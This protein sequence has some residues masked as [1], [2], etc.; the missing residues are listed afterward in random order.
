MNPMSAEF[1]REFIASSPPEVRASIAR[2]PQG[3]VAK[4]ILKDAQRAWRKKHA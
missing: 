3:R 2:N 1:L 4:L